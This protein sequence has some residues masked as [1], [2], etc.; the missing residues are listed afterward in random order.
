MISS[1]MTLAGDRVRLAMSLRILHSHLKKIV[2]FAL[3]EPLTILSQL[4][5]NS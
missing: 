5:I 1:A 3:L 4:V 2:R